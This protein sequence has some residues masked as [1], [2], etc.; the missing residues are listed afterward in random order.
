MPVCFF[1]QELAQVS[2]YVTKTESRE[3]S[4][5]YEY[6]MPLVAALFRDTLED[7]DLSSPNVRARS[8]DI[9]GS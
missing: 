9:F 7:T 5:R 3:Q 1:V 6:R 8:E 4:T 2:R